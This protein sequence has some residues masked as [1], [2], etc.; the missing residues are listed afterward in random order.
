MKTIDFL[1]DK[2]KNKN[3]L[4]IS[5]KNADYIRNVQEITWLREHAENITVIVSSSKNY[6]IRILKVYFKTLW[7][8][9]RRD[10]DYLFV[11]FAPQLLFPL[12]LFFPKNKL[13]VFD[14]FISMF[15]TFVDDRK[16]VK[17]N[18]LIAKVLHYIDGHTIQKSDLTV[19]DTQAHGKYFANEFQ[20]SLSKIVV[21]YI[22]ADTEIYVPHVR[23]KNELFEVIYFGSI[24]PVQGVDI[25]LEAIKKVD[26]PAIHF[27][28]IGPLQKK[29]AIHEEDY[30]QTTF[31]PWLSQ[32]ELAE[33]INQADLALAGHFSSTVGK[34]NRTIAGKTY[35]YLAMDK[36]V[37]LGKSDA[38]YEL[39]SENSNT[40][41]VERG[42]PKALANL[43]NSLA[44]SFHMQ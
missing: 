21:F 41:F 14:F 29:F 31:I 18:S 6:L 25:V 20:R 22:E 23:N 16:K 40:F 7:H 32:M 11:G 37:V 30:P 10:F 36:P 19:V 8:L 33:K 35:I 13:I 27:T 5:T 34:A 4:F 44:H 15:D 1:E 26:N 12:F 42:N 2:V 24:L 43:I 28:I 17:P 38:N 9:M 3:V 39:F